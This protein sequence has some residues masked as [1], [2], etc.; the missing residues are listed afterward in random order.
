[1]VGA[2]GKPGDADAHLSSF[3]TSAICVLSR[4]WGHSKDMQIFAQIS[5]HL[6]NSRLTEVVVE[7][8]VVSEYGRAA[9]C[10]RDPCEA[11]LTTN[12]YSPIY[13]LDLEARF[14]R[15]PFISFLTGTTGIRTSSTSSSSTFMCS[16]TLCSYYK[17]RAYCRLTKNTKDLFC[18]FFPPPPLFIR[19]TEALRSSE[20]VLTRLVIRGKIRSSAVTLTGPSLLS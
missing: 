18:V 17:R 8:G 3:I 20:F 2:R 6:E 14:H 15:R 1:M 12:R 13:L 19:A 7:L 11:M 9:G 10:K 4:S 16:S 5:V